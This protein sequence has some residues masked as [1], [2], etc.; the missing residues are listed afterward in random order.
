MVRPWNRY[1]VTFNSKICM[2]TSQ[3]DP[4]FTWTFSP[5]LLGQHVAEKQ[6]W[7]VRF[8]LLGV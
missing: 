3:S 5:S 7:C 2:L 6:L 8:L 1:Q 4:I